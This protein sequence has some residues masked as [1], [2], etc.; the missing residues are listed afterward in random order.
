MKSV[1][2]SGTGREYKTLG[3]LAKGLRLTKRLTQ[4]EAAELCGLTLANIRAI[5]GNRLTANYCYDY[6]FALG[7]G[8]RER[9]S[10]PAE[11]RSEPVI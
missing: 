5:E 10:G 2:I 8:E 6:I 4:K 3:S 11:A 7:T 9:R 1:A